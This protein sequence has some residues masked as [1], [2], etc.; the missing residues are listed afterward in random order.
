MKQ[1]VR[2]VIDKSGSVR[3]DEVPKPV[4]YENEIK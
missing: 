4:C 2:C 1:I 3:L